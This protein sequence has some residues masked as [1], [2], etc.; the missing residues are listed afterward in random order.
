LIACWAF[1]A[2]GAL[3]GQHAIKTGNLVHLSAQNLMDCSQ[4]FGNYGCNGGLMDYAFEYIKENG[5]I[6][7]ADSYPYEA[8][9]GSCRFKKDTIGA[10]DTDEQFYSSI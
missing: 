4:S 8:V 10:T 3:E 1:T 5:G 6:D 2:T 9:E 7:T